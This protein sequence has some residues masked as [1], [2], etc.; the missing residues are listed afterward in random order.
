MAIEVKDKEKLKRKYY[1]VRYEDNSKP[2]ITSCKSWGV[3]SE[4][5]LKEA[6]DNKLFSDNQLKKIASLKPG[7]T[8]MIRTDKR[9]H[10]CLG[11]LLP[12]EEI[13]NVQNNINILQENIDSLTKEINEK[14][15]DLMKNKRKIEKEKKLLL[16]DLKKLVK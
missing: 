14:A 8:K 9:Y 13:I 11:V 3:P 5:T 1:L 16:E 10:N 7:C 6:I 4:F 12:N 15:G 2:Y